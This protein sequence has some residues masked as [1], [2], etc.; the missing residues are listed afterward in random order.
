MDSAIDRYTGHIVDG[1]Q[2]WY[3]NPVD[4]TGYLC[5]GCKAMVNP[6]SFEKHH[7]V[8]PH[9]KELRSSPHLSWC[10]VE[11]EDDLVKR[12]R[13][14]KVSTKDGFPGSFPSKLKLIDE[15]VKVTS[16][17]SDDVEGKPSSGSGTK[18]AGSAEKR[19]NAWTANTIRPICRT[20][21]HFPHDRHLPLSVPR[22]SGTTYTEV[23]R[24]LLSNG[25]I[26]Y[27]TKHIF[28]A[29]LKWQKLQEIDGK[30]IIELSA[31]SWEDK[32]LKTNY[33][34]I[35]D[36][37]NWGQAKKNYILVDLEAARQEAMERNKAGKKLEKSWV[38]FLA[39]QDPLNPTDFFIS[40]HRLL[41]CI[42]GEL[43]KN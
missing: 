24:K 34:L 26:T 4:K 18:S 13:K 40:D 23:F 14:N 37:S 2:L 1:E 32:Q 33:R 21:L 12:G 30:I 42:T 17:P 25:I 20:Y 6:V 10:D 36:C 3:I 11:G 31:G 28:F 35:V 7:K 5:R 38:F 16:E 9:F 15:N 8:R 41:C 19:H 39:D 22:A 27:P 43:I 29:P